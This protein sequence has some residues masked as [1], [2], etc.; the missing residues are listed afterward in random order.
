MPHPLPPPEPQPLPPLELREAERLR[1]RAQRQRKRRAWRWLRSHRI[2]LCVLILG[3][4]ALVA[5]AS[6]PDPVCIVGGSADGACLGWSSY[7]TLWLV[8]AALLLMIHEYPPDIVL[9]GV[10]L[11]LLLTRV[12]TEAQA[13]QGAASPSVLAIGVLFVVARA[14]EETR[15]VELLLLPLCVYSLVG[16]V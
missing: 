15:S 9:L 4:T 7:W 10:T 2:S 8:L 13:L 12:I 3:S 14:L 11:L 6:L 5:F 16:H 1:R